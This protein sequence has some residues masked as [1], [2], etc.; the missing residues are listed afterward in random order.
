M[1]SESSKPSE[2]NPTLCAFAGGLVALK[3]N[4]QWW[5]RGKNLAKYLNSKVVGV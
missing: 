2:E 1:L 3:D 4:Y 5:P